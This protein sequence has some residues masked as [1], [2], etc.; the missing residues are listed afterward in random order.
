MKTAF[1][2]LNILTDLAPPD[3]PAKH[4][5]TVTDDGHLQVALFCGGLVLPVWLADEEMELPAQ[6]VAKNIIEAI[7]QHPEQKAREALERAMA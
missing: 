5:I 4:N 2:L 1:D 3:A 7:E 6:D